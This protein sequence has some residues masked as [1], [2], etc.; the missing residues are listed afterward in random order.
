MDWRQLSVRIRQKVTLLRLI[1]GFFN[2]LLFGIRFRIHSQ[3]LIIFYMYCYQLLYAVWMYFMSI[4][5][6]CANVSML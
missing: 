1:V 4:I 2:V 6:A 5:V 3:S